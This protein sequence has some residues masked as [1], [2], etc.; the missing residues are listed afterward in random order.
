MAIAVSAVCA[1]LLGR[2]VWAAALGAGL[3]LG[4]WALE[5]AVSRGARRRPGLAIGTAVAGMV[6]RLGFVI[7]A[8]V[9]V[10]LF[11]R[12]SLATAALC[13]VVA[14]TLYKTVHLFT[15]ANAGPSARGAKAS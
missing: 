7:A 2:P 14:F 4:Y 10:A 11:A 3:A 6:L 15:Y 9:L 8:L 1:A 13:F 12:D 5:L